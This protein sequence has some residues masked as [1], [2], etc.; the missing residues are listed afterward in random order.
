MLCL[1]SFLKI[2]ITDYTQTI[3]DSFE[4]SALANNGKGRA[5]TIRIIK[6]VDYSE[7]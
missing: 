1:K 4:G 6:M 2:E 3:E 5:L 7:I